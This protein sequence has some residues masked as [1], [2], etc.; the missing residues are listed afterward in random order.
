M[1]CKILQEKLVLIPRYTYKSDHKK[2]KTGMI[3]KKVLLILEM[4]IL[5]L[6]NMTKTSVASEEN[7]ILAK[8]PDVNIFPENRTQTE[9]HVLI[10]EE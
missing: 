5:I 3:V 4:L 10:K 1:K 8:E 9:K 7:G 2:S 6:L